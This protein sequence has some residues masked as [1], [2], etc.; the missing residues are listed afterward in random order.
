[1]G[2]EA[3][4]RAQRRRA[5]HVRPGRSCGRPA[6]AARAR[7]GGSRF[8]AAGIDVEL[9]V[10]GRFNVE[11]ALAAI[12]SAELAGIEAA[13][14]AA[15]LAAVEGI[16]G[17]FERVDEG[18][19][20]T[21]VVDY[22]HKPEALA[23]VLR[24]AREL[25][26]GRVLC[27]FGAGGDRDPG[28][29]PLMGQ[30]AA[31]LADVA[32]VTSDNPRSED[33][34]AIAAAV[35]GD[36]AGLELELDRRSAIER[37]LR[38]AEPGDVVVIAGKGHE[39]RPGGRRCRPPVRRP[40]GGARGAARTARRGGAR[41]IPLALDEVERLCPGTLARAG[42]ADEVTGV[43]IDSR[44]VV[45]GDLFVAVGDGW[46][47][48]D[49]ALARGAAAALR[50]DDAHAALAALGSTL[51][52]LASARFV[53]ITG[54]VGKT[55]T[56]DILAALCRPHARTVAAEASYNAEL[57][58]PLTLCRLEADTEV[59]VLELAMR[60]F[61]QIHA[62]CEIARPEIG[63]VTSIAPVHLELVGSLDGVARAKGE[64]LAALPAGGVA[65]VPAAAARAR[66]DTRA[67]DLEV[68]RF[69]PGT[70]SRL[71]G[72]ERLPD[73]AGRR[74]RSR[75]RARADAQPRRAPSGRER[76]SRAARISTRS[77]SPLDAA[78]A[79]SA[80]VELS[81]WRGEEQPLPGGGLLVNDAWNASPVSMRAALEHLVDLA[82]GRRTRRRAGRDGRAGH[83]TRPRYHREVGEGLRALGVDDLLAVGPLAAA[84]VESAGFGECG[85]RPGDRGRSRARS[86]SRPGDCVLVKASRSAGL[87]AVADALAG[88][89]V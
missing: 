16:P 69:G 32:I 38:L 6:G 43:T 71:T 25:A 26:D 70:D 57:G 14:V 18:Q 33:P 88:A 53:G 83:R 80:D 63:V 47:F 36:T 11:N 23:N 51:R 40:R 5:A 60:G 62:L 77:A 89:A 4:R 45:E 84:Y 46:D 81:R 7:P 86:S 1:M 39:Q 48:R 31:E 78:A 59:C 41:V 56:K 20:F 42:W 74:T 64:L 15:G 61:G 9:R 28:K 54:S 49:H 8:R 72:W 66:A 3:G 35:R 37:A 21:V 34:E 22:A 73:G 68:R 17:R 44:R 13:A 75:A 87:E 12:A 85:R 2:Q 30:V 67:R 79:G 65:V 29:R 19:P 76:R 55:S 58:V 82:E 10:P 52:D 27:V 24:T 50:P